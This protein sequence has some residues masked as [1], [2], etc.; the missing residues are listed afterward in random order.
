[1]IISL[2]LNLVYTVLDALLVF[3]LPDL[4]SSV[5]DILSTI[6]E[7]LY[8]GLDIIHAF[9]GSGAMGVLAVCLNLV[10]GLNVAYFVYSLVF[11]CLRKVPFFH[12]GP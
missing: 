11:W 10:I 9:I 8:T 12:I 5:S 6:S 4:P 7:Y 3:N 2:L 1:M